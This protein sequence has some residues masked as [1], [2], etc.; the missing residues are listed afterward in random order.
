MPEKLCFYVAK[1]N[2]G[3]SMKK[4]LAF[5]TIAVIT[6]ATAGTASANKYK[7]SP[8]PNRADIVSAERTTSLTD[9]MTFSASHATKG[10]K[11]DQA[12]F[13]RQFGDPIST[14]GQIFE[15][16]Y[17]EYTKVILDC[18]K[19]RCSCRCLGKM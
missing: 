3:E 13:K 17:D 4:A 6:A 15:Y 11:A 1:Q 18:S 7:K 2:K 10:K 12:E 9:C 8:T 14:N 19:G 16:A 5:L